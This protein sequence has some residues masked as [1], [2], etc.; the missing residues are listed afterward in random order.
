MWWEG[1]HLSLHDEISESEKDYV[2]SVVLLVHDCN[3]VD[4]FLEVHYLHGKQDS[5]L[6]SLHHKDFMPYI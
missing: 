1:K 4:R 2:L 5:T 3:L 6:N